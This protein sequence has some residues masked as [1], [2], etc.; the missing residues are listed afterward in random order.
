MKISNYEQ[1]PKML[2]I[3]EEFNE[4]LK[5]VKGKKL[6]LEIGTC[7]GGTL[8]KMMQV[9]D[10][11]AEFVSIDLPNGKFGGDAFDIPTEE[12]MQSWEK[13]GQTLHVIRDDSKKVKG[14]VTEILNGRKFDFAFIDGD[15]TF[16]GVNADFEIYKEYCNVIAFHDI[17]KHSKENDPEDIVGVDKLWNT[18]EGDKI[19]I[20]KNR[21]QGWAGIGVLKLNN[22]LDYY[23]NKK[24]YKRIIKP[25]L[26]NVTLVC[27]SDV[28]IPQSIYALETCKEYCDFGDVKF[29]TSLDLKYEHINIKPIN[30]LGDYSSFV[31]EKLV[32]YIETDYMLI[33]QWD[34]YIKNPKAWDDEFL[35]YDYIGSPQFFNT[36]YINNGGFSLRSTKLMK[37]V[38][39]YA[40]YRGYKSTLEDWV[41]SDIL[42][43]TLKENGFNLAPKEVAEKFS[44]EGEW[45]GQFGF[46]NYCNPTGIYKS[47]VNPE[48]IRDTII[49][50]HQGTIGDVVYCIPTIKK[51][52][53]Q[54]LMLCPTKFDINN[55]DNKCIN[56]LKPLLESQNI[57]I[58]PYKERWDIDYR[59]DIWR[60]MP[61]VNTHLSLLQAQPFN[62]DIELNKKYIDLPEAGKEYDI[63][64]NRSHHYNNNIDYNFLKRLGT[65]KIVFIGYMSEYTKFI[66]E[67][68]W[69]E[70]IETKDMLEVANIINKSKVFMGN[71]SACYAI[72]EG[73][74]SNRIQEVCLHLP[75]CLPQSVNGYPMFNNNQIYHTIKLIDN[76]LK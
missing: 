53:I 36:T 24:I 64:I 27:I 51:L 15:H 1:E 33:V 68:F 25:N 29:F 47:W 32:D 20:I 60:K 12:E 4:L 9:A 49:G 69:C 46:H 28:H 71:Q 73:L 5:F 37:Y 16:D 31:L 50:Q 35:Q 21:E 40:K 65:K 45:E 67:F 11:N 72:A 75:N 59:L 30:S 43:E 57:E 66:N 17:L 74:K 22:N 38:Q 26:N 76:W 39:G 62:I 61:I 7:M 56:S 42:K 70:Y 55:F 58:I 10:E 2:Q 23:G 63:V 41:I 18:I 13:S 14:K 48:G 52:G 8:Y 19:E 44:V 3:E 6:I 34:G 54:Q